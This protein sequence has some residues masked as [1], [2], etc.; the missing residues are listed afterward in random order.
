MPGEGAASDVSPSDGELTEVY[1]AAP[2]RTALAWQRTGL[3]VV[4]SCFVV[5]VAA[6]RT[7]M[8]AV[9]IT[10]AAIGLTIAA[11]SAFAFP[12]NAYLRGHRV[13]SWPLLVIA[14]L[15]VLALGVLG[16]VAS[17]VSLLR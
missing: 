5:F 7:Q 6:L 13:D 4:L 1:G 9:G 15:S 14:A 11:L 17:A 12:V 8:I 16:V 2:E 3:S 10:A